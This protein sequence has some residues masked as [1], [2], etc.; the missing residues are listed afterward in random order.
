MHIGWRTFVTG[1][2]LMALLTGPVHG[3][4]P[5]APAPEVAVPVSPADLARIRRALEVE[6]AVKIDDEQLRFYMEILV[7]RPT[8]AEFAKG[9]DFINGPTRGGNPMTHAEFVAM[10]TP[11]EMQSSVGITARETLEFAFT[12]WLAQTLIKKAFEDLQ[13]A[14]DEREIQAIRDRIDRELA[15]LKLSSGR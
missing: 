1:A 6:P 12:N 8:F 11:K 2:A 14:K 5:L 13:Q 15:A 10:V 3:Q 9:Y 4:A 7:R